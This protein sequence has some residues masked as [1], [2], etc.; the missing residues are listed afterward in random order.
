MDQKGG[1]LWSLNSLQ[2]FSNPD[3]YDNLPKHSMML[4]KHLSN[5]KKTS[6][7]SQDIDHDP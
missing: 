2:D 1:H 6:T 3:V 7:F 4:L 5:F